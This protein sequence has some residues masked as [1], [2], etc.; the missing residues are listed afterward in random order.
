M[1]SPLAHTFDLSGIEIGVP[2]GFHSPLGM[3][4]ATSWPGHSET[5]T[6]ARRCGIAGQSDECDSQDRSP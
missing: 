6:F 1:P 2:G 5:P 3:N 4:A